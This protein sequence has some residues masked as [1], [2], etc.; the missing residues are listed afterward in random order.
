M[1]EHMPVVFKTNQ[2]ITTDQFIDLLNRSTL[3]E[4][5]PVEDCECID[6]ML[7]HTNLLVT[8]WD[9]GGE[10]TAGSEPASA[11]TTIGSALL[12]LGVGNPVLGERLVGIARSVTDFSYCCYLSDLA[13]DRDYQKSGIGRELIALTQAQLGPRCTII[14]LSAPAAVNYYPH[15]GF[16]HHP[17]A[18]LL[19]R[20][21]Q[22]V[23]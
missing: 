13:V 19:P 17:Q 23:G 8:A 12:S 7:R 22:V 4:R 20:D 18:W 16:T 6:S 2:T 5:R 14:L 10:T 9:T 21:K 1:E 3:A 15:I 11:E